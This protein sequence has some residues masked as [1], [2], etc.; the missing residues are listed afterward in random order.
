MASWL[1]TSCAEAPCGGNQPEIHFNHVIAAQAQL[2]N[3][4]NVSDS[5]LDS[6]IVRREQSLQ[7]VLLADRFDAER[8]QT[9]Q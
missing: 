7:S 2:E 9:E 6:E 5:V 8:E 4:D 3:V 1:P